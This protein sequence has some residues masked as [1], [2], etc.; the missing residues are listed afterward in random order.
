MMNRFLPLVFSFLVSGTVAAAVI[1]ILLC[2]AVD[3]FARLTSLRTR[4]QPRLARQLAR[5]R[6]TA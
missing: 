1:S 3:G 2:G 6:E 4:R 5:Q